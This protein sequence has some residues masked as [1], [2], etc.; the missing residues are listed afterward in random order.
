VD[1]R[2]ARHAAFAAT[3]ILA[4]AAILLLPA[5]ALGYVLELEP[6]ATSDESGTPAH[7]YPAATRIGGPDVSSAIYGYLAMSE[8]FDSYAFTVDEPVTSELTVLVPDQARTRPFRPVATVIADDRIVA[9]IQDPGQSVDE[10]PRRFDTFSGMSLLSGG[11]ESVDFEPGVR[12]VVTVSPGRGAAQLGSYILFMS[13]AE[14]YG[15][16]ELLDVPRAHLG[17]YGQSP[18]RWDVLAMW[19]TTLALVVAFAV[20]RRRQ[21]L[22]PRA[23]PRDIFGL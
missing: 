4:L 7:P 16:S 22:R 17:L 12:Y 13:G 6:P 21:V 20:S 14:D 15:L 19:V 3:S 5:T 8:K 10:R 18:F 23:E 9:V 11:S 1:I 2:T